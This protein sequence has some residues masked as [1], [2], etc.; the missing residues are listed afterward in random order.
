MEICCKSHF[1]PQR[2]L[3]PESAFADHIS[4]EECRFASETESSKCLSLPLCDFSAPEGKARISQ[5]QIRTRDS[6]VFKW[7]SYS[8]T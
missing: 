7:E 1:H 4:Q 2:E 3:L 6:S 5:L 8:L